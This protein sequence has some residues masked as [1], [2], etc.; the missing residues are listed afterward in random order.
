[1]PENN[2]QDKSKDLFRGVGKRLSATDVV[3]DTIKNLLVKKKLKPGDK[4][5]SETEMAD[6]LNVSRGSVREA[7]KILSAYGIV[8]VR[9]G[10]GT[11][12]NDSTEGS[13]FDPLLF[14]LIINQDS[15]NE[16]RELREMLEVGIVRLAVQNA[17]E[18]DLELIENAFKYTKRMVEENRYENE[19]IAEAEHEFHTSLGN[20]THNKLII[21]IYNYIMDLYI[22]QIYK[23]KGDERFGHEALM[24]HRPIIDAIRNR[25]VEAGEKAIKYSMEIWKEQSER[26]QK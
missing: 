7:M 20:A 9:R 10:D 24:S 25:D 8:S 21:T 17:T 22:P 14:K 5:P 3:L 13:R 12:I 4:L 2:N 1:L 16:L 18:E 6:S 11:Y 19:I 15:F 23:K 26:L